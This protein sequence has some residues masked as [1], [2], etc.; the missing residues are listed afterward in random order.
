MI[1]CRSIMH[2]VC[3]KRMQNIS[4]WYYL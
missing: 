4:C 1:S 3:Q 2:E